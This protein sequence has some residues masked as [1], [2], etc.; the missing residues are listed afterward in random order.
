MTIKTY[1]R[2]K[3]KFL[4]SLKSY[5]R[6]ECSTFIR[7]RKKSIYGYIDE[8]T[9]LEPPINWTDP[10]LVYL[11]ACKIRSGFTLINYTGRFIVKKYT[12]IANN[13]TVVTGNHRP[14]VGV[15]HIIGGSYH[16]NDK[17]DD[18]IIEEA[19]W[20]GINC[21]LL[22]GTHIGRGSIIG[23]CSMVN[24]E[25]PPYAVAVG[26]PAKIIASVFTIEQIIEHEKQIYPVEER[27]SR[28]YLEELFRLYYDGKK[29]IGLDFISEEQ[30]CIVDYQKKRFGIG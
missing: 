17:E 6:R 12:A 22:A 18:I 1:L 9:I 4:I 30:K 15:P 2:K 28:D 19:V 23:A 24:K 10:K 25:I 7:I 3:L 27:F 5:W 14:T 20:I 21:T 13:C 26:S 29:S 11:Y 16:I 8:K